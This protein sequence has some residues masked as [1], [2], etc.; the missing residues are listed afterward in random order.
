M[1]GLM[2]VSFIAGPLVG[3]FLADHVGWRWVFLVNLPIGARR[4]RGRRHR[5]A[6]VDRAQRGPAARRST[7]PGIALLTLGD[8]ARAR[9]PERAR[10]SACIVA[11]AGCAA[12][13][14]HRGRAPRRRAD[15]PAAAVRASARRGAILIAGAFGAFGLFASVLLLPR[16]F[17]QRR[18]RRAPRTPAC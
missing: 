10:R 12:R 16:Y 4:A 15:H 18:E 7:S 9:R 2:G 1:A 14:V 5:A 17:Q 6:R 3:G 8:R 11:G 13:R